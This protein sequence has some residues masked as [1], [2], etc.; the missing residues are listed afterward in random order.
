[1]NRLSTE[2][3]AQV[4]G[5]LVEGMSIRGTCRITGVARMTVNKLLL[6]AGAACSAYQDAVFRN[7][8]IKRIEAD[9]IWAFVGA[10]DENVP[11][12]S[13]NV[14]AVFGPGCGMTLRGVRFLKARQPRVALS[15]PSALAAR[16]R[17]A[18][19]VRRGARLRVPKTGRFHPRGDSRLVRR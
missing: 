19:G 1:M 18:D 3:R 16:S 9:E 2:K 15:S 6:D 12:A 14:Y 4:I 7:L 11:A 8:D 17:L 10:K 5:C 13:V